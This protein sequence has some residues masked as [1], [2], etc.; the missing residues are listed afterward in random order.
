MK[1]RPLVKKLFHISMV[2]LG[3]KIKMKPRVPK[4]RADG[5]GQQ[6]PYS[7]RIVSED[8][9]MPRICVAPTLRGCIRAL[10]ESGDFYV[11]QPI[12]PTYVSKDLPRML[13]EDA[14][15]TGERWILR[16]VTFKKIGRIRTTSYALKGKWKWIEKY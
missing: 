14:K 4:N 2:D 9:K 8:G 13:V 12:R 15:E 1:E 5:P 3:D 16:P 11:Y 6:H 7:G 10:C